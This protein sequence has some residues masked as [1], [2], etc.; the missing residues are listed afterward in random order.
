MKLNFLCFLFVIL[1]SCENNEVF[2]PDN[3]VLEPDNILFYDF[4]PDT[5]ITSVKY[6]LPHPLFSGCNVP[7]PSDSFA[8]IEFDMDGDL[9]DDFK[10]KVRHWYHWVSN[11]S[12]CANYNYEMTITALNSDY[13]ITEDLL[14]SLQFV[15]NLFEIWS[16]QI[17][18]MVNMR[19]YPFTTNFSGEKYIGVK[20][21]IDTCTYYGWIL[22]EKSGFSLALKETAINLT[23]NKLILAG[24][25]KNRDF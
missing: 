24:Q 7:Y 5:S 21:Q 16:R 13:L 20:K 14:D 17:Y 25:K 18:L 22:V 12:P 23:E 11:S 9:I 1:I 6:F 2:E 19:D 15:Y 8:K 4:Q 10:L 3:E